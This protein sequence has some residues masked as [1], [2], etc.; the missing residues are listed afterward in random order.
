[1]ASNFS[2]QW[3][4]ETKS[5]S[6][7]LLKLAG[8][9]E[10]NHRVIAAKRQT[11]GKGRRN[12][13]WFTAEGNIACSVGFCFAENETSMVAHAP[14]LVGVCA[15]D[16]VAKYITEEALVGL[17]IKWPNDL[18]WRQQ[19]LMGVLSQSRI[20]GGKLYL[21]IGIGLNIAWAPE[22]LPAVALKDIP[23]R[24]ECP[25]TLDFLDTLL[26]KLEEFAPA[27]KDYALLKKLWEERVTYLGKDIRFGLLEE[28]EKMT[29]AKAISLDGAGALIVEHKD[30]SRESLL[31]QDLS[32]RL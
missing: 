14:L 32:L 6:A 23:L 4:E 16:A 10:F 7:D 9:S 26:E 5:T 1:M 11:E 3:V 25:S 24:A 21:S 8:T 27:W 29:E 28:E 13:T 15:Y 2:I 12:R 30:G 20:V 18:V 22:D 17:T 19:K 31:T